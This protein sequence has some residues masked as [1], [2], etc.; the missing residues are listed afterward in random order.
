MT[1]E[2]WGVFP[3][4]GLRSEGQNLP[5]L[6]AF[7]SCTV[8]SINRW[9]YINFLSSPNGSGHLSALYCS[10]DSVTLFLVL[11]WLERQSHAERFLAVAHFIH[12]WT[13]S[14]YYLSFTCF[15]LLLH[16]SNS[17]ICSPLDSSGISVDF[18][19]A[20]VKVPSAMTG[21]RRPVDTPRH[22]PPGSGLKWAVTEHEAGWVCPEACPWLPA[23]SSSP[24][25]PCCSRITPP[26]SSGPCQRVWIFWK[27]LSL[28]LYMP[29]PHGELWNVLS[30]PVRRIKGSPTELLLRRIQRDG[31][32]RA[33][34]LQGR[35][36]GLGITAVHTG[37]VSR[38]ETGQRLRLAYGSS[39]LT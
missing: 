2:R 3:Q 24:C 1:H 5:H 35:G 36:R 29:C 6:L 37:Y 23:H 14:G 8:R 11:R 30:A 38:T 16:A 33:P 32:V 21:H 31:S 4:H 12:Q 19:R 15:L 18:P 17:V 26:V 28:P 34:N 20:A 22:I 13:A 9:F 25:L 27:P 10:R 7:K 39:V